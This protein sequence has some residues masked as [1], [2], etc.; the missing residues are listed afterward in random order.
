MAPD[1]TVLHKY[2]V[3]N[4]QHRVTGSAIVLEEFGA[5][6]A[7]APVVTMQSGAL[8]IRVGLSSARAFAGQEIGF[9]AKFALEPEWHVYETTS[10][11]FDD[12]KVV[13]QSFSLEKLPAYEGQ[14]QG[15][16]SVLLK[17]PLD[18]GPITLSGQIQFQQCSANVCEPPET[19][20]FE[21]S[22]TLE[23]FMVATPGG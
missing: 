22:L 11:A 3:P 1:G 5:V 21:L 20:P 12:P 7:N 19:L 14:F 23:P 6:E 17:F 4:Y 10:V 18:A 13:K 9:F 8:T 16:G 2:F 15:L